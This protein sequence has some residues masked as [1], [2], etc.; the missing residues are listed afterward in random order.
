MSVQSYN[1]LTRLYEIWNLIHKVEY[2]YTD[3]YFHI[4]YNLSI[5]T[6]VWDIYHY[7]SINV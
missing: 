5:G 7:T 2:N 4:A 3:V 1:Q 6:T